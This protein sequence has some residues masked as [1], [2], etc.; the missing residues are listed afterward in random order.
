MELATRAWPSG[1]V[2]CGST[3]HT[4][5]A[6]MAATSAGFAHKNS[7]LGSNSY[8]HAE[9]NYEDLKFWCTGKTS[10]LEFPILTSGTY[11]GGDPG[12]DRVVFSSDDGTYCAVVTHTGASG[13]D[14]VSCAGD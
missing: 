10:F 14:F 11:S 13:D 12:A 8:P 7:P 3:T 6:V 1:S 2:T 5:S 4:L 9:E